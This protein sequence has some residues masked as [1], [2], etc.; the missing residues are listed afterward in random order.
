MA[1][2]RARMTEVQSTGSIAPEG[3]TSDEVGVVSGV[4]V[5]VTPRQRVRSQADVVRLIIAL[6]LIGVGVLV[7]TWLRNT[8]GGAEADLVDVYERVPDRF[9]EALTGMAVIGVVVV[10]LLA[11]GVLISRRRFRQAGTLL[12]GAVGAG[13]A[14]AWLTD[15]LASQGVIAGVDPDTD[16]VVE[17][18]SPTFATSPLIAAAVAL[19]IIATPWI[20]QQWR[21]VLWVG[22]GLLVLFRVVSS[23]EP[24]LDIVIAIA[25]GMAVGSLALLLFGTESSDPEAPELVEM[26]RSVGRPRRIEQRAGNSPLVYDVEIHGTSVDVTFTLTTQGCPME[27]IITNGI[28]SATRAVPGVA[29][30]IP[31]L[32]W[33]PQW[34]PG[35]MRRSPL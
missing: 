29:E 34:H 35:L 27:R 24:P 1:A 4:L 19:V 7:A 5:S 33:D 15:F 18:T 14:M 3:V 16:R 25:V 26:L 22:V 30:V 28:V 6:A 17:L 9:A 32:V 13:L 2:R 20:S 23:S 21:R 12:F 31:N 8:L 11:L 10:P